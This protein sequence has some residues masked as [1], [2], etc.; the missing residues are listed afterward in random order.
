MGLILRLGSVFG[1]GNGG[2]YVR[3]EREEKVFGRILVEIIVWFRFGC[4]FERF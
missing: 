2:F 3:E 4:V 1:V